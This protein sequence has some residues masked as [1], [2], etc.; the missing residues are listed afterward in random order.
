MGADGDVDLA[1]RQPAELVAPLRRRVAAGEQF[2]PQ[3]RDGE[4]RHALDMLAGEDFGRRHHRRLPPGLDGM[5]HGDERD[6]G[7]AGADVAL[8]QPDHA[9]GRGEIGADLGDG[10]RLR[11]G[12]RIGQRRQHARRRAAPRSGSGRPVATFMRART[13]SSASWLASSSS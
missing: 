8:K 13:I 11:A 4:R 5:A 12:Q 10:A 1:R 7:L 2:Q 3:A 6:D 9:P